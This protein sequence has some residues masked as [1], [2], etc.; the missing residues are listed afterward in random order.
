MAIK[1]KAAVLVVLN[2]KEIISN[3][4]RIFEEENIQSRFIQTV[5]NAYTAIETG[6]YRAIL[7]GTAGTCSSTIDFIR[8]AKGGKNNKTL[9]L[10]ISEVPDTEKDDL[11]NAG[12]DAVFNFSP[13]L[14]AISQ[15]IKFAVEAYPMP[16]RRVH[17]RHRVFL[18]ANLSNLSKT[19]LKLINLSRGGMFIQ[20]MPPFPSIGFK[21][22]FS[23]EPYFNFETVKGTGIV[24][25]VT[26]SSGINETHPPGMGIQFDLEDKFF[27][28]NVARLINMILTH[29]L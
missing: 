2:E 5:S 23:I 8:T 13:N 28:T 1:P 10:I 12:A 9:I 27:R 14:N 6:S 4:K 11:L 18:E 25:W 7:Y 3:L 15:L 16:E 20:T 17:P 19:N 26:Q 21:V 22:Q 29:S 24:R